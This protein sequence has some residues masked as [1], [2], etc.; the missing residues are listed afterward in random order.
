[1]PLLED[2]KISLPA[3]AAGH[4]Q[5]TTWRTG[6]RPACVCVSLMSCMCF[7]FRTGATQLIAAVAARHAWAWTRN[8]SEQ[9]GR[10]RPGRSAGTRRASEVSTSSMSV[11]L[12]AAAPARTTQRPVRVCRGRCG[13][14]M[15]TNLLPLTDVVVVHNGRPGHMRRRDRPCVSR[16]QCSPATGGVNLNDLLLIH[17]GVGRRDCYERLSKSQESSH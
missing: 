5:Q 2:E 6:K 13:A 8:R 3:G 14:C 9:L 17:Q 12:S 7:C 1:V 16:Q 15:R 11:G 4:I 10:S